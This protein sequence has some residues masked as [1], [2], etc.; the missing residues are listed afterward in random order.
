M[1][2]FKYHKLDETE[3]VARLTLDRPKHNV[4]NIEML[5][6]F[7]QILEQLLTNATLKCVV[8]QGEGR[9]WCAGVDVGDHKPEVV[10]DMITTFG[11]VFELMDQIPVPVIAA[12]HGACLGGGM[13]LA[14]A[15][16]I[17]VA[18]DRATFGQPEI[19]LGFLPPYAAIRLPHLVGPSKAIEVCTTGKIY[20]ATEG[21]RMG[22]ISHVAPVEIFKEK[23]DELIAEIQ[24][25]SP[26][27]IRLNKQAVKAHLGFGFAAALQAVNNLF[28]KQLMQTADTQEGIASFYEKRRPVWKNQ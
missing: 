19:K 3:G 14:I 24:A 7:N 20:S 22:F 13:E 9:S 21:Q 4:F 8:I 1:T 23:V 18:S 10:G 17:V 5:Q 2:T 25:C 15:C 26:L 28:L 12:V 16:D 27:I 11:R 6:E